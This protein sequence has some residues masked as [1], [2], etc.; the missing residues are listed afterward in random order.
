MADTS[1]GTTKRMS[2]RVMRFSA[3]GAV[4]V[5][6]LALATGG[7]ASASATGMSASA[8]A[9]G[10]E[11][12]LFGNAITGGKATVCVNDNDTSNAGTACD[13]QAAQYV[14]AE[15]SGTLTPALVGDAKAT[16]SG[17]NTSQS[18]PETCSQLSGSTPAGTPVSVSLEV[19]CGQASASIDANGNGKGSAAGKVA[20]LEVNL[21]SLVNQII[22]G[23]GSQL[24]GAVNQ[25]LTQVNGSPL[26]GTPLGALTQ[27]VQQAVSNLQTVVQQSPA[28][29]TL[30]VEIGPASASIDMT[31]STPTATSEGETLDVKILPGVGEIGPNLTGGTPAP[32][33]EIKIAPAQSTSTFNG[34]SWTATGHGSVATISLNIPGFNQTIDVAPGQQQD[35]LAGTPLETTIDLGSASTN[36]GTSQAVGAQVDLLKG[37]QNGILLN[38]GQTSSAGGTQAAPAPAAAAAQSSPAAP[39]AAQ[40]I[41]PATSPTAVHTGEW[42]SGSLPLLAVL[43]AFGAGLIGW[44][45]LRRMPILAKLAAKTHR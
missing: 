4:S 33:V 32:L 15:G 16:A 22:Q 38:L 14:A 9:A 37:V 45:R 23:G 29:D 35:I 1:K 34:T 40:P 18:S 26:G 27:G 25:V 41:A 36:G 42:W 10:L 39:A 5:A 7:V 43:A 6:V 21:S 19:A 28:P 13:Q 11:I 44:P 12:N 3:I 24:F 17:P 20:G 30:D 2:R 31:G 8:T